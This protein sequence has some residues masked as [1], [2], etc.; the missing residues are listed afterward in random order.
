MYS[1]YRFEAFD[2]V[3]YSVSDGLHYR[4]W[5]KYGGHDFREMNVAALPYSAI[6]QTVL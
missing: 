4:E 3:K 5:T 1:S 6:Y 2:I